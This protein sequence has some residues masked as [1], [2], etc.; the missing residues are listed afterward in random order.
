MANSQPEKI[1]T[2]ASA[3]LVKSILSNQTREIELRKQEEENKKQSLKYNYELAKQSL[4]AQIE[5]R[6]EQR[7][8]QKVLWKWLMWFCVFMTFIISGFVCWA[9]YL[10]KEN[11][12]LEIIRIIFYGGSG[13]CAGVSLNKFRKSDSDTPPQE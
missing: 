1:N 13:F 10:G 6:K 7:A 3:E 12:L 2:P 5:D 4:Q 11:F 9:L 8:H